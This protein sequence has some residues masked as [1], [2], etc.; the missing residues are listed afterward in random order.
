MRATLSALALSAILLGGTLPALA[1]AEGGD[2]TWL[3]AGG[4]AGSRANGP[5]SAGF[6]V[7]AEARGGMG[8]DRAATPR[9]APADRAAAAPIR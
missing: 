9:R 2:S 3:T 5:N 1:S 6:G 7:T 8:A 4:R